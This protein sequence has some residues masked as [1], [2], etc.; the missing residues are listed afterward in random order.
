MSSHAKLKL[1]GTNDIYDPRTSLWPYEYMQTHT[2]TDEQNKLDDIHANAEVVGP[3]TPSSVFDRART[4]LSK[5][6]F[7]FG[8]T[9]STSNINANAAPHSPNAPT[10]SLTSPRSRTLSSHQSGHTNP[11]AQH[12]P[13]APHTHVYMSP[14]LQLAE[15]VL[16]AAIRYF[17][18]TNSYDIEV[19]V[20]CFFIAINFFVLQRGE[21][22]GNIPYSWKCS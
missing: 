7:N 13:L 22:A 4:H 5:H 1:Y 10:Y 6:F 2:K 20:E 19:L 14:Q 9:K 12:I 17:E 3:T 18:D 21:C 11:I 16:E 15:T 8:K